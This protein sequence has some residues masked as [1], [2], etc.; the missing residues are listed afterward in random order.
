MKPKLTHKQLDAICEK[1]TEERPCPLKSGVVNSCPMTDLQ[2]NGYE[3]IITPDER[4]G[5]NSN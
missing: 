5:I 2:D 4:G 3:L 1:C